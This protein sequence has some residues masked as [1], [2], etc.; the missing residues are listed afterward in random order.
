MTKKEIT[1]AIKME[2]ENLDMAIEAGDIPRMISI[3]ETISD[4]YTLLYRK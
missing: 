1:Q 3:G 4:L 2:N